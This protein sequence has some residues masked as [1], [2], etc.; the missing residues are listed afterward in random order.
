LQPRVAINQKFTTMKNIK[1]ILSGMTIVLGLLILGTSCNKQKNERSL[2]LQFNSKNLTEELFN[3]TAQIIENRANS[4]CT[5]HVNLA[6]DYASGMITIK[7]PSADSLEKHSE[8]FTRRGHLEF[9]PLVKRSSMELIPEGLKLLEKWTEAGILSP[10]NTE[11]VILKIPADD[12]ELQQQIQVSLPN[13]LPY[14]VLKGDQITDGMLSIYIIDKSGN[15]LEGERVRETV[16]DEKQVLLTFDQEGAL[17]FAKMT[18]ANIDNC[19]AIIIDNTVVSA[20]TVRGEITGGKAMISGNFSSEE[21]CLLAAMLNG[22]E[23]QTG[24]SLK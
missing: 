20:P 19:I 1:H 11:N 3:Q 6:K 2:T 17:E 18:E 8:L 22:G 16:C 24:L 4:Y 21:A 9:I 7:Y 12:M 10:E 14:R 13:S 23:L 15:S 5:E